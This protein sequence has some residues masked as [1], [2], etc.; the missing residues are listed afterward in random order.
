MKNNRRLVLCAAWRKICRTRFGAHTHKYF[1]EFTAVDAEEKSRWPRR[2]WPWRAWSCRFPGRAD[3]QT[4]P[5]GQ[6]AAEALIL[7][8]GLRRKSTIFR[9]FAFGFFRYR[10]R[11]LKTNRGPFLDARVPGAADVRLIRNEPHHQTARR[12][13][14]KIM[15]NH[16]SPHSLSGHF[17][18]SR[19]FGQTSF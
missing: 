19:R 17:D 9:N 3:E 14:W 8:P 6:S 11:S 16:C 4:R 2:R 7:L 12:T 1:C 5:L 13:T 10:L 15:F 18:F